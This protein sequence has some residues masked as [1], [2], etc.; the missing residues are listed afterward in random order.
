MSALDTRKDETRLSFNHV[1]TDDYLL[2]DL[3]YCFYEKTR[4]FC[5]VGS[6]SQS[7]KAIW[8]TLILY[9]AYPCESKSAGSNMTKQPRLRDCMC[10]TD[11]DTDALNTCL[12]SHGSP[13]QWSIQERRY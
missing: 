6:P 13:E 3:G 2:A 10:I 12:S 8:Y 4:C 9:K 7:N 1:S 11:K 5:I